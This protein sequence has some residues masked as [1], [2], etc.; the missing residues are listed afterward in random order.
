MKIKLIIELDIPIS[1]SNEL[2]KEVVF[3]AYVNYVTTK[4]AADTRYWIARSQK[5]LANYH[6]TWRD[7]TEKATWSFIKQ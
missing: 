6:A 3:D 2:S 1:M 7:I 4:H 5:I